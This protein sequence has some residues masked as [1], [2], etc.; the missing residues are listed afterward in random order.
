[1]PVTKKIFFLPLICAFCLIAFM[2]SN[3]KVSYGLHDVSIPDSIKTVKINFIENKARS[4][5]VGVERKTRKAVT[6]ARQE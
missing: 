6:S 5:Q 1:M 2:N 4:S 3:C